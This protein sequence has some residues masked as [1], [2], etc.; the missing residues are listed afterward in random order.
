MAGGFKRLRGRTWGQRGEEGDDG[1]V[2]DESEASVVDGD[3]EL[4]EDMD[5]QVLPLAC[6]QTGED[7]LVVGDT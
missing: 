1:S 7:K 5:G 2:V 6:G 3:K 4:I